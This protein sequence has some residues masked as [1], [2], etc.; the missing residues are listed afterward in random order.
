MNIYECFLFT[1]LCRKW[2][3]CNGLTTM[4]SSKPFSMGYNKLSDASSERRISTKVGPKVYP[5]L[6]FNKI[7]DINFSSQYA[8]FE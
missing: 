7:I 1:R 5:V 2:L 3:L 8:F 6:I 4:T